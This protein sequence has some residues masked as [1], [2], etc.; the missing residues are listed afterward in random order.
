[1][2]IQQNTQFAKEP[3]VLSIDFVEAG[4][5]RVGDINYINFHQAPD[6][7]LELHDQSRYT[8]TASGT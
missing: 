7:G 4:A 2:H 6:V 5:G 8:I 1:M 3:V